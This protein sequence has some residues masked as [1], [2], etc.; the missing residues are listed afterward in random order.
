MGSP[1]Q[2]GA[3]SLDRKPE[4]TA[5]RITKQDSAAWLVSGKGFFDQFDIFHNA[6]VMIYYDEEPNFDL[7]PLNKK[8][9][10]NQQ[11][12]LDKIDSF[13]EKRCKKDGKSFIPTPRKPWTDGFQPEDLPRTEAVM[14]YKKIG[15]N[16]QIR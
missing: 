1:I 10:D 5:P 12:F 2:I 3:L 9:W 7:I 14:G 11:M 6:G 16:Q 13:T 4:W 8:A 15:S